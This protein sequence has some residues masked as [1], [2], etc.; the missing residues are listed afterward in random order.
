[1]SVSSKIDFHLS[2]CYGQVYLLVHA[3]EVKQKGW[4]KTKIENTQKPFV[5]SEVKESH[6]DMEMGVGDCTIP[7]LSLLGESEENQ[8]E[9]RLDTDKVDSAADHGIETTPVEG[10]T[11]SCEQSEREGDDISQK[12]HP[13]VLW[14]VFRRKDVPK[15]IEY[16][17][18]HWE[19]FGKLKSETNNFVSLSL[20][21]YD[22]TFL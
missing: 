9:A 3:C 17:R 2:S 7:D 16:L 20:E 1:M 6:E 5:E 10:N 11:I 4:Q 18:I 21:Y 13:G 12:S 22:P 19:E 15:L 8:N 14:D